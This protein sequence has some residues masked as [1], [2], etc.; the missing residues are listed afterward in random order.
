MQPDPPYHL[1]GKRLAGSGD[2]GAIGDPPAGQIP[3]AGCV[4]CDRCIECIQCRD[5]AKGAVTGPL[6]KRRDRARLRLKHTVEWY[7]I[8]G[9]GCIEPRGELEKDLRRAGLLDPLPD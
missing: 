7:A 5:A 9:V 4:V 2:W 1:Y 3:R 8:Y 6:A